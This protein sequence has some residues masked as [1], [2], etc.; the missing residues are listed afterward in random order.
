MLKSTEGNRTRVRKYV[1]LLL[2]KC[3]MQKSCT[4]LTVQRLRVG[5][6]LF[7]LLVQVLADPDVL[8]HALEFGGVL[9]TARLLPKTR[10]YHVTLKQSRCRATA[11]VSADFQ[12][13]ECKQ[14]SMKVGHK[15]VKYKSFNLN[16]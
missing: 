10:R 8:E 4:I 9:K 1:N 14:I 3:E 13:C 16:Y 15:T 5:K 11:R 12:E 2:K 7:K 6:V